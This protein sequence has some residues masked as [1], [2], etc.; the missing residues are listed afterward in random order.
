[1]FSDILSTL[2]L[3]CEIDVFIVISFALT[4]PW[5]WRFITETCRRDVFMHNMCTRW[6]V[7]MCLCTICAHVGV[8]KCVYAQYV[9]TLVYTYVFMHN[10]CTRWCIHMCLCTMCAQVG[11]YKC[12]YAQYVHT[13]VYTNDR[14]NRCLTWSP[15]WRDNKCEYEPANAWNSTPVTKDSCVLNTK[16]GEKCVTHMS[17]LNIHTGATE[18]KPA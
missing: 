13:L 16:N 11:V 10:M 12:V 1:M 8:Y 9:H 4:S 15:W 14:L 3:Y 17:Q 6:C 18:L 5:E 7:Q 2:I